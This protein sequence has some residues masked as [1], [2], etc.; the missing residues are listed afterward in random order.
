MAQPVARQTLNLTVGGSN[1]SS[2]ANS[3]CSSAAE[4]GSHKPRQRLF[5]STLRDQSR[6]RVGRSGDGVRLWTASGMFDS[7]TRCQI[8]QG[9]KITV[10]GRPPNPCSARSNRASPA[11]PWTF[12]LSS[13]VVMGSADLPCWRPVYRFWCFWR[14]QTEHAVQREPAVNSR[15]KRLPLSSVHCS[16]V[17]TDQVVDHRI[18][19]MKLC[20][21]QAAIGRQCRPVKRSVFG[22]RQS[23]KA[24]FANSISTRAEQ[25]TA[26]SRKPDTSLIGRTASVSAEVGV[27]RYSHSDGCL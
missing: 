13:S 17:D 15:W 26:S 12:M 14:R 18:D 25:V 22:S 10:V 3:R 19:Q 5:N 24:S 1:P 21:D 20:G 9:I 6:C 27:T 8:S 16:P 4:R 7:C 23:L 2:P 11:N